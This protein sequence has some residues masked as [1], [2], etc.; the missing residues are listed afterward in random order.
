L[1]IDGGARR[2]VMTGS[3]NVDGYGHVAAIGVQLG[4]LGAPPPPPGPPPPGPPPPPPP[5]PPAGP[6]PPPPPMVRCRVPRVIHLRLAKARTKIR[7]AHCR[8]GRVRTARARRF[9]GFVVKQ[10]PR[11]GRQLRERTRVNLVLGRR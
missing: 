1:L 4:P 10:S 2:I 6:P 11:A 9:R 7:R 3:T 5:P 8:V